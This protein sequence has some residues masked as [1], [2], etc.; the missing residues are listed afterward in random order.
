MKFY[1]NMYYRHEDRHIKDPSAS[2]LWEWQGLPLVL[3]RML[4]MYA[5][6][7]NHSFLLLDEQPGTMA[8]QSLA[9]LVCI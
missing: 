8:L 7:I 4:T 1:V 5:E 2:D 6:S 9:N 3:I